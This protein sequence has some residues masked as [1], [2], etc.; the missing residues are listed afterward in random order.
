MAAS[1]TK[2][3]VVLLPGLLGSVLE[4][5]GK[6]VWGLSGGALLRA[7]TSFGGSVESLALES[8]SG[9]ERA[10]D[11][12][13]ATKVLPDT[14]LLPGFWKVDGYTKVA[15]TLQSRFGLIPGQNFFEFPY[16]WRRDIRITAKRL[17]REARGWLHDWRQKYGGDKESR[18]LLVGH[19]MGGIVSRYFLECLGGWQ[20][21][22]ALITFGTPHRG[23]FMA[24]Q[25][26]SL[27]FRKSLG[28][29]KLFDLSAMVRS[30]PSAYQLLP[31][32][33]CIQLPDGSLVRPGEAQ[34]IPNLDPAKAAAGLAFQQEIVSA[35]ESNSKG[36]EYLERGYSLY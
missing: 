17:E 10:D 4:R 20:Y 32:Y 1:V 16:D 24:L 2:D 22:R 26:L 30:L 28:P 3:V 11:G 9:G 13:V 14:Q 31:T 6:E 35:M 19:S 18:L 27:G 15:Q 34:G 12:V 23:S 25:A 5:D 36:S 29:V 8:D 7:M 33:R 21:T